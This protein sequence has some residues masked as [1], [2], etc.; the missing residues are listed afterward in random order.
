MIHIWERL[1]CSNVKN[2][3][4]KDTEQGPQTQHVKGQVIPMDKYIPLA[5]ADPWDH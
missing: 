5:R 4:R 3:W 2:R 1:I